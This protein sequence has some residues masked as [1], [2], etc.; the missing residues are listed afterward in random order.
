[1][2]FF[3]YCWSKW[4]RKLSSKL[5]SKL[6]RNLSRWRMNNF[7][8]NY[9]SSSNNFHQSANLS[10]TLLVTWTVQYL[11]IPTVGTCHPSSPVQ[12]WGFKVTA[13]RHAHIVFPRWCLF[14]PS[15]TTPIFRIS[16]TE[17]SDVLPKLLWLQT[18]LTL[19]SLHQN[20]RHTQTTTYWAGN[21]MP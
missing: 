5:R 18:I 20:G 4:D 6:H 17:P 11:C 2:Y 21:S 1:M 14:A 7:K 12:K 10:M 16:A 3:T 19:G 15:S 13:A 9:S 8:N